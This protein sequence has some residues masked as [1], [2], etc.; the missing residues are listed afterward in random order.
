MNIVLLC[1]DVLWSF[2]EI[3]TIPEVG[4][5]LLDFGSKQWRNSK[6]H[7]CLL[8]RPEDSIIPRRFQPTKRPNANQSMLEF[9]SCRLESRLVFGVRPKE[10]RPNPIVV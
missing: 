6:R 5:R 10:T 3:G 4:A 8:L 2:G 7:V 1:Y 9:P